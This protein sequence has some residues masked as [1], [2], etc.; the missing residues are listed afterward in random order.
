MNKLYFLALISAFASSTGIELYAK[1]SKSIKKAPNKNHVLL[2]NIQQLIEQKRNV[3]ICKLENK[4]NVKK[5]EKARILKQRTRLDHIKL[6]GKNRRIYLQ[7]EDSYMLFRNY[8]F[9]PKELEQKVKDLSQNLVELNQDTK[10][11]IYPSKK[12]RKHFLLR[13]FYTY[14][15]MY[16]AAI[17]I[18]K[19]I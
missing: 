10:I 18:D 5:Q 14:Q 9:N 16:S 2:Q 11:S 1:F 12:F 13:S 3:K 19:D 8:P 17:K 7:L 4:T 6:I 15:D